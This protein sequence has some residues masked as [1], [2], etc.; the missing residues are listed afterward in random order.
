MRTPSKLLFVHKYI[1]LPNREL[2]KLMYGE[3]NTQTLLRVRVLKHLAKRKIL[4]FNDPS[5]KAYIPVNFSKSLSLSFKDLKHYELTS[6]FY[7]D[8]VNNLNLRYLADVARYVN[9]KTL[10]DSHFEALLFEYLRY[11]LNHFERN[12]KGN[13]KLYFDTRR[14]I[15]RG[16]HKN[17]A[18]LYYIIIMIYCKHYR[19]PNKE[20]QD[21][22][23]QVIFT[24]NEDANDI[25]NYYRSYFIEV[26]AKEVFL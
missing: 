16:H 3:V 12:K 22:I 9:S 13:I 1:H 24:E 4:E 5:M 11:Y 19:C 18:L 17:K 6:S 14:N 21:Y 23:K 7:H 25:L 8:S 20:N 26:L 15:L 10:K 2:A